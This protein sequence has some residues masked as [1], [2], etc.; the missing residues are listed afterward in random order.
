MYDVGTLCVHKHY[1]TAY[2][3][4]EMSMDD[5]STNEMM[6]KGV[7]GGEEAHGIL[8]TVVGYE[9]RGWAKKK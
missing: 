7:C 6:E 9:M 2:F 1:E 4:H 5:A 8:P 3:S